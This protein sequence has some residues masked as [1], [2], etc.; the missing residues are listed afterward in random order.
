L[1]R[2]G[3]VAGTE[4]ATLAKHLYKHRKWLGANCQVRIVVFA[5]TIG[6]NL[7]EEGVAFVRWQ[8]VLSFVRKRF[9]ENDRLKAEHEAWDEFGQYLWTA[10]T[11]GTAPTPA[12]LFDGW[13][14]VKR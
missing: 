1:R 3:V 11:G 10:L 14:T 9:T 12:E 6:G 7:Q 5:D 8:Q 13:T 4:L 2:V